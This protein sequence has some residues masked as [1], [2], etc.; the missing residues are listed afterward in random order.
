MQPHGVRNIGE[1]PATYFVINW[2]SPGA[3]NKSLPKTPAGPS[4]Q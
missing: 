4:T 2:S 3:K 1:T